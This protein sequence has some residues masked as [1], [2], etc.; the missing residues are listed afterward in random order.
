MHVITHYM[1]RLFLMFLVSC[2]LRERDFLP[3]SGGH[4][5]LSLG[6]WRPS[7]D[8]GLVPLRQLTNK[9]SEQRVQNIE[10]LRTKIQMPSTEIDKAEKKVN[11]LGST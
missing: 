11:L 10:P 5:S 1:I 3:R 8:L 6:F 7:I 4:S 2:Y 9:N